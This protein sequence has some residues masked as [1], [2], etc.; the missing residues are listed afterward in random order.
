[1]AEAANPEAE[2]RA[3]DAA[4]AEEP[5]LSRVEAEELTQVRAQNAQLR[6]RLEVGAEGRARCRSCAAAG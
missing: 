1:M 4:E 6:R 3:D 5:S 2:R